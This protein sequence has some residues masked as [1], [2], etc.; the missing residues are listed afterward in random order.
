MKQI[1]ERQFIIPIVND[2]KTKY[3]FTT[4]PI[5]GMQLIYNNFFDDY[6]KIADNYRISRQGKA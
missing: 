6:K 1:R 3:Y 5:G 4:T 2:I